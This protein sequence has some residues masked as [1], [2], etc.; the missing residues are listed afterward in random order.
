LRPCGLGAFVLEFDRMI[1]NLETWPAACIRDATKRDS[2]AP[3]KAR[4]I[5]WLDVARKDHPG[6]LYPR[7][8]E[9][10]HDSP[11]APGLDAAD[12]GTARL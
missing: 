9:A 7:H 4:R 2:R 6:S 5:E 12:A 1:E 3:S 8:V 11:G 10:N